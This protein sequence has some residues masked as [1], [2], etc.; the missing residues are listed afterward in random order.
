MNRLLSCLLLLTVCL[1]AEEIDFANNTIVV[2]KAQR[3]GR[4]KPGMKAA[5]LESLYG[6]ENFKLAELPGP[7]ATTYEGAKLFEGTDR[8]LNIAW[9][10]EDMS[11]KIVGE[12]I[13]VG[14]AWQFENGLKEGMSLAEVEKING[15]PFKVN[16]FGWDLGGWANFEGGKLANKVIVYFEPKSKNYPDSVNGDQVLS[17]ASKT[18]RSVK[19]FVS[20]H[21]TVSMR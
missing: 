21:I 16:G 5:E 15:K 6:K 10:P 12:V 19:P 2:G 3:V 1:H 11:K 8:E 17:S 9:H 18:L 14:K 4:I 7:E 20:Q 13:V